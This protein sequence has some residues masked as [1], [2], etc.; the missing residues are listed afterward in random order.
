M[1]E[2]IIS[3]EGF[4]CG[5]M[6]KALRMRPY[7]FA[8]ALLWT[9]PH[10]VLAA[11]ELALNVTLQKVDE[12]TGNQ[13]LAAEY[14]RT[15]VELASHEKLSEAAEEFVKALELDPRSAEAH[16]NLGLIRMKSADLGSAIKSFG[17]A[18]QLNPHYT[19]AQLRLAN[20]LTQLARDDERY[21]SEAIEAYHQAL[22]L[23]PNEPEAHCNLGFLA[24]R[25]LDYRTAT[26]EYE[27]T[28]SLD[29]KYPGTGLALCIS[30]Y[31]L[32]D[33]HRADS[34]C[35]DVVK[36]EPASAS[37]HHYLGLVMN[38]REEW[39]SAVEELRIAVR[40]DPTDYQVHYAFA[41]A[42]RKTGRPEE[43]AAELEVVRRMQEGLAEN[44]Q[45]G[46]LEN[47]TR[48]MVEA[49]QVDQAI[50]YDRQS[51]KLKK[52]ARTATNLASALLWKG[53]TDRGGQGATTSYTDGSSLPLGPLL[54]RGCFG[55]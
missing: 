26:E 4:A 47:Q 25:R 3:L 34:L 37:A 31:K 12:P 11:E 32:G 33:F 15:G 28:L 2:D 16:Y 52:D 46:F 20:S 49:G 17:L 18:L 22:T 10:V 19:M 6:V 50:E 43:A 40:L 21:V 39:E 41:Q 44:L 8:L 13:R 36:N 24:M 23:D 9:A 55:P 27:K 35:R 45:A 53:N 54:S 7:M 42:L 29:P 48:K 5:G 30:V 51:L 38:K 14:L 1:E